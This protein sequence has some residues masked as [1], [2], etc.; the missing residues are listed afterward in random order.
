MSP[1]A[2]SPFPSRVFRSVLLRSPSLRHIV[3][4]WYRHTSSTWLF[5][6]ERCVNVDS[7]FRDFPEN[8]ALWTPDAG[9]GPPVSINADAVVLKRP[10]SA[11]KGRPVALIAHWDPGNRIAP[12]VEHYAR[13]LRDLGFATVL[14]SGSQPLPSP[15]FSWFDAVVCRTCP[16]YDFTS[17]KAALEALPELFEADGLI[18]TNDSI[19][20]PV[21]SFR[22]ILRDMSSVPC[23]V[24]GLVHTCTGV[25]HLQSYWLACRPRALRHP[26]F[27]EFF[28]RVPHSDS[29]DI[30]LQHELRFALWMWRHSLS[31]G[32]WLPASSLPW[33]WFNP[34][35][36]TWKQMPA[37]GLPLIKRDIF[38]RRTEAVLTSWKKVA[39]RYGYPVSLVEDYLAHVPRTF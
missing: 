4:W 12:Y 34:L 35:H 36:R 37:L 31:L 7:S 21:G 20:A 26:A 39:R 27:A 22:S 25:P 5:G 29:R 15:S 1:A 17:W 2:P 3:A 38:T 24:W 9:W 30:A 19:F 14:A 8:G 6:K 23:D 28:Q 18:L 33:P 32:A 11:L 13:H 10:S 16:G